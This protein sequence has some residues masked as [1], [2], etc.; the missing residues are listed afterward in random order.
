MATQF[1]PGQSGNPGGKPKRYAELQA[2]SQANFPLAVKRLGELIQS[3][4]DEMAFRAI[5]FTFSYLLGKPAEARDLLQ[6]ESMRAR[7]AELVVAPP[8]P[9]ALPDVPAPSL[10]REEPQA[11]IATTP[12]PEAGS[13]PETPPVSAPP[14]A[15]VAAEPLGFTMTPERAEF[16][17]SIKPEAHVQH[18]IFHTTKGPCQEPADTGSQWCA[19]HKAKLFGALGEK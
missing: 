6:L 4:D 1:K 17:E 7:V 12:P 14:S 18:C 11:A 16:L 10:T 19:P 2:L 5:A 3:K 9:E 15:P 8:Q 13:G